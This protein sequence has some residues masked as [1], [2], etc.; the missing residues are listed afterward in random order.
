MI[1]FHMWGNFDHDPCSDFRGFTGCNRKGG[2]QRNS[3][4]FWS[5]F[6]VLCLILSLILS[7]CVAV[8]GIVDWPSKPRDVIMIQAMVYWA[9]PQAMVVSVLYITKDGHVM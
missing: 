1:N 8:A 6:F 9:N 4:P 3:E 5:A 2:A 7:P